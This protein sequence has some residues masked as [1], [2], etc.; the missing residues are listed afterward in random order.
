M[1]VFTRIS[2]RGLLEQWHSRGAVTT[3]QLPTSTAVSLTEDSPLLSQ[4][5]QTFI[6]PDDL[7]QRFLTF[8][9]LDTTLGSTDRR[10]PD[11]F[12]VALLDTLTLQPLVGTVSQSAGG[13]TYTDA[14][15]AYRSA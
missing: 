8:D 1:S 5:S 15:K 4:L 3:T 13:L 2:D 14:G 7:D 12:E 11:A 6:V 10:P 9:L